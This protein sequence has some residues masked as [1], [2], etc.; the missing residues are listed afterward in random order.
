[1]KAAASKHP[2]AALTTN[3]GLHFIFHPSFEE[4]DAEQWYSNAPA[5][6]SAHAAFRIASA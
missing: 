1:M 5:H 4:S 6:T 2:Q 3:A